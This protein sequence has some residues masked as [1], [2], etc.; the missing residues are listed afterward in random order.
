LDALRASFA[1]IY[2]RSWPSYLRPMGQRDP[3]LQEDDLARAGGQRQFFRVSEH[4]YATNY[5]CFQ[6]AAPED[7]PFEDLAKLLNLAQEN[8][9]RVRLYFSPVHARHNIVIQASGL[10]AA[11]QRYKR[12]VMQLVE[13]YQ[14]RGLDVE[15]WDFSYAEAGESVPPELDTKARMRWWWESSHGTSALGERVLASMLQGASEP[16]LG[17]KL[18]SASM[19]PA[20]FG[21]LDEFQQKWEA[22]HPQD[23]KAVESAVNKDL[24]SWRAQVCPELHPEG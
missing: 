24:R 3:A 23:A 1:T 5:G 22:N 2:H 14:Q 7:S 12:H 11:E 19:L 4:D 9:V 13:Q 20:W 21:E 15:L 6:E 18:E 16:T 10:S 17:K 8:L